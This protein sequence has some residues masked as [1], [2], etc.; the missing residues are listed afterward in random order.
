MKMYPLED[1]DIPVD[2]MVLGGSTHLVWLVEGV[3]S[4]YCITR[5]TLLRGLTNHVIWVVVS[6]VFYFHPY[7]GEMIQ[8]DKHIFQTG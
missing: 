3:T 1:G 7:F 4:H 5:R 8:F 2:Q 6:N